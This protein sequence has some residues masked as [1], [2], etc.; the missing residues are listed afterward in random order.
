MRIGVLGQGRLGYGL[1]SSLHAQ[2]HDIFSWARDSKEQ[3]WTN[4]AVDKFGKFNHSPLDKFII[5]SGSSNPRSITSLE[6]LARTAE[7][8]SLISQDF[9][10]Q[11]YYLS[12]G[13]VYGNCRIP[14]REVDICQPSTVYGESKFS[15]EEK[16]RS[17]LGND[18]T[19]FRIGN[20]VPEKLDFGIFRMVKENLS[21][22]TPIKLMG[23]FRDSR[24][25]LGEKELISILSSLIVS[26]H[27]LD[28]LNIG[29]GESLSLQEIVDILKNIY[30]NELNVTWAPRSEFDVSNTYLD[31]SRLKS[32]IEIPT[33]NSKSLIENLF[34]SLIEVR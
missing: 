23:D 21:S 26:N 11:I 20:I 30:S 29:S 22:D 8:L 4:Q 1:A 2:G 31:V 3:A 28:L 24:D 5:A 9:V 33:T 17:I 18:L 25:Y 7:H 19:I 6:E 15:A 34:S 12:S 32:L 10:G 13:A 14:M 16:L 27:Q